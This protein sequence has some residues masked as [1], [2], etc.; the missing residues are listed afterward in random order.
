MRAEN[1]TFFCSSAF[2]SLSFFLDVAKRQTRWMRLV[3]AFSI[4]CWAEMADARRASFSIRR[5]SSVARYSNIKGCV[6]HFFSPSSFSPF[7]FSGVSSIPFLNFLSLSPTLPPTFF[8]SSFLSFTRMRLRSKRKTCSRLGGFLRYIPSLLIEED[9][10]GLRHNVC[11]LSGSYGGIIE[12]IPSSVCT[13]T[14]ATIACV[15][16]KAEAA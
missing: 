6:R 12:V 9:V 1:G 7:S 11:L 14:N 15:V 13:I 8:F 16:A 5:L 10:G 4:A 2:S 3:A